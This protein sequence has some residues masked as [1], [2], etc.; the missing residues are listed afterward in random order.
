MDSFNINIKLG[1][2][3]SQDISKINYYNFKDFASEIGGFF[4]TMNAFS[5]VVGMVFVALYIVSLGNVLRRK[6][7]YRL[8]FVSLKKVKAQIPQI[9]S[10][11]R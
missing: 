1:V 11:I 9:I 6:A 5:S 2:R 3:F 10:I 7:S 4:A 8:D